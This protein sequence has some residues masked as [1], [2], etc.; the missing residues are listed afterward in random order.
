MSI[1]QGFRDI[2]I[3]LIKNITILPFKICIH[4]KK[5]YYKMNTYLSFKFQHENIC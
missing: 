5:V 1:V 3:L 2:F 4:N